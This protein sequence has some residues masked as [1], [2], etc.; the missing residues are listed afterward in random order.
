VVTLNNNEANINVVNRIP[1]TVTTLTTAAS[2]TSV[3]FVEAGVKLTVKPTINADRRIT[4]K[5]KP[6]VSNA[7]AQ[8][9]LS[10]PP[11]INSRNA[12]TTVLLRDG[13]TIAIGGLITESTTKTV[14]GIPV[15]MKIPLLGA[16][17]RTSDD[18]VIRTELIVFLTPKIAAE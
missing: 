4:L 14:S 9:S 11:S 1:Y 7:G 13:E 10:A 12:E 5:V 3:Q 6:E 16:L 17:F 2:Q 15:L 8:I 18:R